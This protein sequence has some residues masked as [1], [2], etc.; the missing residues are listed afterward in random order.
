M[1]EGVGGGGVGVIQE[2]EGR[3]E[4]RGEERYYGDSGKK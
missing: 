2:M 1:S 3:E 4:E